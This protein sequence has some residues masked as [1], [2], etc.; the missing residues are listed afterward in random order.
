MLTGSLG[1]KVSKIFKSD[2]VE[3]QFLFET[4]KS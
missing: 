2:Q 4:G 3:V 1:L